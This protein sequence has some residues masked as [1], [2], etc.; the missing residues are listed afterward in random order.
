M[1]RCARASARASKCRTPSRLQRMEFNFKRTSSVSLRV[2]GVDE[3]ALDDIIRR[4][5]SL[6][7]VLESAEGSLTVC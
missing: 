2:F 7:D 4:L 1:T 3:A 5:N 6:V